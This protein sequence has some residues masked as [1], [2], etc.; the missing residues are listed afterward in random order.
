MKHHSEVLIYSSG[1]TSQATVRRHYLRWRAEQSPPL[2]DRC[3]NVGCHFHTNP[4]IWNGKEL[5]L[6]LDHI[7]GNNADNRPRSL[8]LLCPNCDSQL[9]TRGGANKGRVKKSP[10][11]FAI[12]DPSGGREFSL[13]ADREG[14]EE[15]RTREAA[16]QPIGIDLADRSLTFDNTTVVAGG[17]LVVDGHCYQVPDG[18]S[19]DIGSDKVKMILFTAN[20]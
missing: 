17:T 11:G 14:I 3:D 7:Q 9:P 4:L 16:C 12:I 10:S 8:R 18:G 15:S 13:F 2:P 6:I 20:R 1:G 5:P 19:H